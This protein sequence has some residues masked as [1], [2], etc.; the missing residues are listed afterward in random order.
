M[1]ASTRRQFLRGT[2]GFTLALPFLESLVPR[3]ARAGQAPFAAHP[4]FVCMTTQ[5]GGVWGA[6]MFPGDA[7]APTAQTL[8]SGHDM[9]H[10]ALS[11]SSAA[12]GASL[13]AVLTASA[14]ALTSQIVSKMNVLRGIDVPFYLGHHTGG[15]LG[16]YARNDGE[17]GSQANY[18][19]TIDQVMAY[20]Q[21]FYP[22]LLTIR[23]RSLHIGTHTNHCWGY[24]NPTAQT[25]TIDP[26]PL[27]QSSQALF[28]NIF[29][30]EDTGEPQRPL[31]VDRVLESYNRLRT[32]A[33]GDASRLGARDRQ[34]LDE[35][36]DRL[37]DLET[38]LNA[39]ASCGDVPEPTQ[40]T[41]GLDV[42]GYSGN[43][44]DMRAYYQLYN[45]VIVAAFICGTSRIAVINSG[46][47][48]STQHPGLCCDW[49]DL[50]AH[51]SAQPDGAAQATM[52]AAQREFF[53]S[54]FLDLANKL[55]VE[56]ANG[57]TYLENS[58]LFWTQESGSTTHDPI[59]LPI[60]S[61]G[62]AA[63][64]FETGTYIDYRNRS[65]QAVAN[66]YLPEHALRRPG[67]THNRFLGTVLQAMGLP[68]SE[69]ELPGEHGYGL[70]LVDNT[71]AWS[72]A[73]MDDASEMLPVLTKDT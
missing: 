51:M 2:A 37:R 45:D 16:N 50:V 5:H 53:E 6:N 43:V 62:S 10:G 41:L 57:V 72:Q 9:H 44:A 64:V 20:S 27:S 22:D 63:G 8:Y 15:D 49:H 48:W 17:D 32:G 52:V 3:A 1:K 4:R 47:T 21:S 11:L 71:E 40:D 39:V 33:F 73:M 14:T 23:E 29:V 46:E 34:R 54:V 7:T 30:P 67:I 25:G 28:D 26:I 12:G 61:A 58:F 38:R 59:S 13:S 65:S 35:H 55:D 19:P 56:E 60:V 68:T 18:R 36:M 42:G 24:S 70:P 69:F 66:D 31:V